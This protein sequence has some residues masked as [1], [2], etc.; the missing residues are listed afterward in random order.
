MTKARIRVCQPKLNWQRKRYLFC[1][2][3]PLVV[4]SKLTLNVNR[5]T[6]RSLLLYYLVNKLFLGYFLHSFFRRKLQP[7]IFLHKVKRVDFCFLLEVGALEKCGQGGRYFSHKDQ[8]PSLPFFR[9]RTKASSSN[10]WFNVQF[11]DI[12][13]MEVQKKDICLLGH[14]TN[15]NAR[16]C[17]LF[18]KTHH[19]GQKGMQTLRRFDCYLCIRHKFREMKDSQVVTCSHGHYNTQLLCS[20]T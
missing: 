9:K 5:R 14:P 18:Q 12:K 8:T 19:V 6:Q 11:C 15:A 20:I 10:T 1:S 4:K 7:L 17:Y 13:I 16:L 3:W 2:S